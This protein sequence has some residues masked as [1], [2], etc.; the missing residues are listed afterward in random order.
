MKTADP[1]LENFR[2]AYLQMA[3]QAR[4]RP[5]AP[6]DGFGHITIGH[7]ELRDP[8]RLWA[9]ATKYAVEFSREEDTDSFWIG[10]SDFRTAKVFMWVIEAAR[11]LAS[12]DGGNAVAI[13]LLKMAAAEVARVGK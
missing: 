10:V 1:R 12:G 4:Y 11:V 5:Q 8:T 2:A 3:R 13:R 9:E 6:S 7:E